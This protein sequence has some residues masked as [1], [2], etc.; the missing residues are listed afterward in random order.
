MSS[1]IATARRWGRQMVVVSILGTV[2]AAAAWVV[3]GAAAA[4]T[5][6]S[7]AFLLLA[8]LL[9]LRVA[10]RALAPAMD[11]PDAPRGAIHSRKPS[12]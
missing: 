8:A 2:L 9:I 12:V 4:A 3:R 10:A 6:Y 1:D 11:A 7:A 5:V